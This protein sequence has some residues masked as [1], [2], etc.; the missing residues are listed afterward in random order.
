MV[1]VSVI[2]PVYNVEK[3]LLKCLD[4]IKH[5]T[6]EDYEVLVIN[7]GST[8]SSGEIAEL[9]CRDK[10]KFNYFSHE[11]I[12][13]GPTRNRGLELAKGE[14]VIFV[15]SDDTISKNMIE[16]LYTEAK[17]TDS[18]VVAGQTMLTYFDKENV[19][20]N[21]FENIETTVD[22]SKNYKFFLENYYFTGVY[23]HM[24]W[25]KI[26]RKSVIDNNNIVFGNNNLMFGEDN[27]FQLQ[28]F[29]YAS[30]ISFVKFPIYYYLQRDDSIMNSY[31]PDLVARGQYM[32]EQLESKLK[33]SLINRQV[34]SL[35]AYD[36]IIMETINLIESKSTKKDFKSKLNKTLYNQYMNDKIIQ[37]TLLDSYKLIKN[38]SRKIFI[39]IFS[40][41]VRKGFSNVA[42]DILYNVYKSK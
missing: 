5:Q 10:K 7:D 18:D 28:L 12:K 38:K 26:Y 36:V 39:Y 32:M 15:D 21:S 41:L 31:K 30:K 9:Y 17:L 19:L 35:L 27:F 14:Y 23:T 4:S 33:D 29:Q 16:L 2:V 34:L 8:D 6:F 20:L 3:Y 11:N 25:D 1:C 42:I 13:L 40:K 24:A 37:L 22:I